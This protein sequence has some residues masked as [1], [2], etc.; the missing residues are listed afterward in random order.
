MLMN[1]AW[2]LARGFLRAAS[3]LERASIAVEF[4][5]PIKQCRAFMHR[6]AG[7]KFFSRR[8]IVSISL[9]VVSEIAAREGAILSL[10]L[11]DDGDVWGD[12]LLLDEPVQHRRRSIGGIR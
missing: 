9:G 12:L 3:R 10:R 11:V 4:A 1:V 5:R 8:T 6:A 7:S 2:D